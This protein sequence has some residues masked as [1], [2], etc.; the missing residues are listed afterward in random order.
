MTTRAWA[1]V[2]FIAVSALPLRVGAQCFQLSGVFSATNLG[3]TSGASNASGSCGGGTA[4][5]AVYFYS[6]PRSGDYTID[7]IGSAFDTVL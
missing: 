6:A 4:A 3:Q 1:H 2:F 5:D 7:T